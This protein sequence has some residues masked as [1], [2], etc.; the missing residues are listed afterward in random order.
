MRYDIVDTREAPRPFAAALNS[1]H[2]NVFVFNFPFFPELPCNNW[3]ISETPSTPK[4]ATPVQVQAIC[5][6]IQFNYKA[7]PRFGRQST[8]IT[9]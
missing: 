9:K 8:F 7:T 5:E 2:I 6:S 1:A 4:S 3:I